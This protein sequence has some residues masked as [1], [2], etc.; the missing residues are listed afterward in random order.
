MQQRWKAN[1]MAHVPLNENCNGKL[2][3]S[4]NFS[5][6][7]CSAQFRSKRRLLQ[8]IFISPLSLPFQL[9]DNTKYVTRD[10][11]LNDTIKP[12]IYV[13]GIDFAFFMLQLNNVGRGILAPFLIELLLHRIKRSQTP[14]I[15]H[16]PVENR[17]WTMETKGPRPALTVFADIRLNRGW[18]RCTDAIANFS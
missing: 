10:P 4:S 2:A 8:F 1:Q 3:N 18:P 7:F 9:A 13:A 5:M 14:I 16:R 15:N 17:E 11:V 12:F 6:L